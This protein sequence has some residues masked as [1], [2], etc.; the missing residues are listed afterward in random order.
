MKLIYSG[1]LILSFVVLICIFHKNVNAS[2]SNGNQI[3]QKAKANDPENYFDACATAIRNQVK[4]EFDAAMQYLLM[5]AYFDQ[6]DVNL[7]GI[8]YETKTR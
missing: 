7:P 8:N 3:Q 5:G 4:V 1:K 2:C 6:D